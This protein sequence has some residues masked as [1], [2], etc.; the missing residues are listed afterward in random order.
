MPDFVSNSTLRTELDHAGVWEL[1]TPKLPVGWEGDTLSPLPRP[2][3]VH[4]LPLFHI[5][6]IT[7]DDD[8]DG[9]GGG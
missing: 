4:S 5:D 2:L 1:T 7:T 9:G 8:D 3:S 6:T